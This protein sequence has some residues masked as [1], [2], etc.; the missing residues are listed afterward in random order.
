MKKDKLTI[1]TEIIND[2]GNEKANHLSLAIVVLKVLR[3]LYSDLGLFICLIPFLIP[4][5]LMFPI[6]PQIIL[7]CT[8]THFVVWKFVLKGHLVKDN[9]EQ[10]AEFDVM[11]QAFRDLKS[12]KL[13]K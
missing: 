6:T 3:F 11:I 8:I 2:F 5:L 13:K 4:T 1:Y 10:V 7:I 9:S 12:E